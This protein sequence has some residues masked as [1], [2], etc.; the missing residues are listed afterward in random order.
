ML[1]KTQQWNDMGEGHEYRWLE[2]S[3]GIRVGILE[4]H[5]TPDG[6]SYCTGALKFRQHGGKYTFKVGGDEFT[7]NQQVVC[8][9]CGVTGRIVR[10]RWLNVS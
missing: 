7:I 4:R 6:K 5:V 2:N 1:P 3:A 9:G 8:S 10:S